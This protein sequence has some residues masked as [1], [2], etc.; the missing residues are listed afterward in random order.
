MGVPARYVNNK[1][2]EEGNG[3]DSRNCE[4]G[5]DA[6]RRYLRG[7]LFGCLFFLWAVGSHRQEA[8]FERQACFEMSN[9]GVAPC[10]IR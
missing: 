1:L 8:C 5:W 3:R 7:R 4:L 10:D 9:P 2:K 6:Y